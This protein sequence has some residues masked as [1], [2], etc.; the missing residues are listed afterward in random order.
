MLVQPQKGVTC[1]SPTQLTFA[2]YPNRFAVQGIPSL[3]VLDSISGNI[4]VTKEQ[5]RN[6]I[7]M[8]CQRGEDEII[9]MF[10]QN[11]LQR[12]PIESKVSDN[13]LQNRVFEV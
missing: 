9:R 2:I 12:I 7:Q 8:A 13:Y 1:F 4:A 11:W 3:L 10:E 5:S 6:E